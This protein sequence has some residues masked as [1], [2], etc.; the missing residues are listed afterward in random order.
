MSKHDWAPYLSMLDLTYFEIGEAFDGL[1]NENLWKRPTPELL[2]IGEMACH[3]A[4]G[5]ATRL[6]GEGGKPVADPEKCPVKSP[7]IDSRFDY[8]LNIKDQDIPAELMS[9]TSEQVLT[10][11]RRVHTETIAHFT[12]ADP[13]PAANPPGWAP[14]TYIETVKYNIFHVS[15]HTGQMYSVRFLL[16]DNPPN[17]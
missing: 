10:E 9:L 7:L 3:V 15:Y 4:Y 1:S 2:S 6:A 11:L 13:D 8:Y 16:G 17:N 5:E 12:A 14:W